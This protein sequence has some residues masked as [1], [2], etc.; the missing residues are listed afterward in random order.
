VCGVYFVMGFGFCTFYM[1]LTKLAM[2]TVPE[3]GKSHFFALYSV[4]GSLAIGIFPIL[5]GI[6][7]DAL[8]GVKVNW[9]GLEWN[10]F[11]IYFTALLVVLL[12]TA[13]QVLRVEE[14]KAAHLNELVSDLLRN[15]P[16]R[17]WMRR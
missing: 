2:A 10:Q 16:L 9:L 13:V 14:K 8:T 11:S 6:L 5:W 7:I 1:S 3:L 17:E 12:A 4:V 15:N